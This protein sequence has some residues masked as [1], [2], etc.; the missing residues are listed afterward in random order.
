MPRD[1]AAPGGYAT[2]HKDHLTDLY[3]KYNSTSSVTSNTLEP[4]DHTQSMGSPEEPD[5]DDAK[6]PD[7]DIESLEQE[8][9][10]ETDASSVADSDS[11][12]LISEMVSS[13]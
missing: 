5:D 7:C 2:A 4:Q 11:D 12:K 10:D 13:L 1:E 6:S 8:N 3:C 9:A